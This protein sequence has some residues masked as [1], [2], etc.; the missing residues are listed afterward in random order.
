MARI[1]LS[2]SG[3]KVV[4]VAAELRPDQAR[5]VTALGRIHGGALVRGCADQAAGVNLGP[6]SFA[7]DMT[8]SFVV[9]F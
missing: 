4:C 2:Q 6:P 5:D 8:V 1:S 7:V 3:R 9:C